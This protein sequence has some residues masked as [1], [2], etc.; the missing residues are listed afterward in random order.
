VRALLPRRWDE[1][2]LGVGS[3]GSTV[4][5]RCMTRAGGSATC[6]TRARGERSGP[7]RR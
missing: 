4:A 7:R 2:W 5:W 1:R 6:A 3:P